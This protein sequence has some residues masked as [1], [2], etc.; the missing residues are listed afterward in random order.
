[1]TI[2]LVCPIADPHA[3]ADVFALAAIWPIHT[4]A[5]RPRFADL[6]RK[7][8]GI[9][10]SDSEAGHWIRYHTD[11][12]V[13]ANVF[14]LTPQHAAKVAENSRLLMLTPQQLFTER[15]D[16]RYVLVFHN[17]TL[18]TLPNGEG[19]VLEIL[20]Q[21]LAPLE[22]EL[23]PRTS[24][25]I[26]GKCDGKCKIYSRLYEIVRDRGIRHHVTWFRYSSLDRRVWPSFARLACPAAYVDGSTTFLRIRRLLPR[27]ASWTR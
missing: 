25:G 11:C 21:Q 9:A 27:A 14:L 23:G 24:C 2:A 20:R 18:R 13:L 1:M 8:P 19:P 26:C 16:I 4:H 17:V 7:S 3:L 15:N 12:S 5:R 22:G 6:C 10:L